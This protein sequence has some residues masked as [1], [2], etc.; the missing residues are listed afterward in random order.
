[1][2]CIRAPSNSRRLSPK[3]CERLSC[4]DEGDIYPYYV[5]K[6]S[7]TSTSTTASTS[8]SSSSS[9]ASS[10][11]GG[12]SRRRRLRRSLSRKGS[13]RGEVAEER[14]RLPSNGDAGKLDAKSSDC[15][16][17]DSLSSDGPHKAN[18]RI[19]A[20]VDIGEVASVGVMGGIRPPPHSSVALDKAPASG[21]F[22]V[23]HTNG[24]PF[25]TDDMERENNNDSL[26]VP[27]EEQQQRNG[28]P[29]L[30][31][32]ED[33]MYKD[34][35]IV[36]DS[37]G[38]RFPWQRDVITQCDG[39]GKHDMS[40]QTDISEICDKCNSERALKS[41]HNS[42]SLLHR[43][44]PSIGRGSPDNR[45]KKGKLFKQASLDCMLPPKDFGIDGT[46]TPPRPRSKSALPT[47]RPLSD[48]DVIASVLAPTMLSVPNS[49]RMMN[50]T[51]SQG[52]GGNPRTLTN[53]LQLSLPPTDQGQ[54]VS[55]YPPSPLPSPYHSPEL[56]VR[57]ATRRESGGN[58]PKVVVSHHE[59]DSDSVSLVNADSLH[60]SVESL[61]SESSSLRVPSPE[62]LQ[63]KATFNKD[64]MV[65][66]TN[67][68]VEEDTPMRPLSSRIRQ[69]RGAV[70][71][72]VAA[73]ANEV[74][75]DE[76]TSCND[77]TD[78][79]P[80]AS[81]TSSTLGLNPPQMDL[82]LPPGLPGAS[83]EHRASIMSEASTTLASVA[84]VHLQD[85]IEQS[86]QGFESPGL[87]SDEGQDNKKTI[88]A[89]FKKKFGKQE[90]SGMEDI[91]ALFSNFKIHDQDELEF[92]EFKDKHWKDFVESKTEQ[93][94]Q[95]NGLS[96]AKEETKRR[97]KVWELFRSECVFMVDHI[98]VLK[99][100]FQERLRWLQ[101]EGHLMHIEV[102]KLFANVDEL[103]TVSAH[104]CRDLIKNFSSRVTRT[105]FGH[106]EAIVVA[107]ANFASQICPA[108][109]RY[110]MN[111]SGALQ[112]LETLKKQ[113]D[114][115]EF[116]KL[117]EQ[118]SRCKRLQLTDFLITPIQRITKYTLL[119]RD[120]RDCTRDMN[121][122]NSLN[123]TL[124]AVEGAI[125]DLEGKVKWL[126]NFER[127]RELQQMVSW[128]PMED[129]DSK[130]VVP[131]FLK[132]TVT[133]KSKD[134]LLVSTKRTLVHEGPLQIFENGKLVDVYVFLFDDMLLITRRRRSNAKKRSLPDSPVTHSGHQP[135]V[136]RL[137]DG[138]A[139]VVYKPP[140][141]L[142]RLEQID[143]DGKQASANGLKNCL[144]LLQISRYG[145]VTGVYTFTSTTEAV[146]QTWLAHL[147]DSRGK[148]IQ[149]LREDQAAQRSKEDRKKDERKKTL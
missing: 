43:V 113:E 44:F 110:C 97:D 148:W 37:H 73:A 103:C 78:S 88:A 124:Q 59:E 107:F 6:G 125:G 7:S 3:G 144:V 142:D 87:V 23:E 5:Q 9:F 138:A 65:T 68:D 75:A 32:D 132:S 79:P 140:V 134:N 139:F 112:Y 33:S 108:Y 114:F 53:T 82:L 2:N 115:A 20:S 45:R 17:S 81:G 129:L 61:T 27:K 60:D 62:F 136:P 30:Q 128:P 98:L 24:V 91:T 127:L 34:L 147:R 18:G 104:F 19:R 118:S 25:V 146:K 84:A 50:E 96:L 85:F 80:R 93:S 42:P 66:S 40:V 4:W 28:E 86:A 63:T 74:V 111:Y 12:G 77:Q 120:I 95:P 15:T 14:K 122:R 145:Q 1:M 116:C 133:K 106:T 69:R 121:E 52:E 16:K 76:D 29:D 101:C 56:P 109:S 47:G 130:M 141:P 71:S 22:S 119:L 137:K 99:E 57:N 41:E 123:A 94:A 31:S 143:I 49:G 54:D 38:V 35:D 26:A 90:K 67:S 135:S 70:I 46:M 39:V 36:G 48:P 149:A 51:F 83:H 21:Q 131:D 8:S 11:S 100:I 10:T 102:V 105:E 126:S 117:C 72:Q 58:R 13:R 55:S 64:R 89:M 92:A